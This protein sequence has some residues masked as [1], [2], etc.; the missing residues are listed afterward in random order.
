MER[1]A[2]AQC[3]THLWS[4]MNIDDLPHEDVNTTAIF[5]CRKGTTATMMRSPHRGASE[6]MLDMIAC[7]ISEDAFA[8]SSTF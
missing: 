7:M 8:S 4:A 6:L 2:T 3:S 5:Q 1:G